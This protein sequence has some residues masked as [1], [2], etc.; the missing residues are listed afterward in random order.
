MVPASYA[1]AVI[2]TIRIMI[3]VLEKIVREAEGEAWKMCYGYFW[4]EGSKG[5]FPAPGTTAGPNMHRG[6]EESQK[7][8]TRHRLLD[9]PAVCQEPPNAQHKVSLGVV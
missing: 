5:L 2:S 1:P 4:A 7:Q 6:C 3:R 9:S 8:V